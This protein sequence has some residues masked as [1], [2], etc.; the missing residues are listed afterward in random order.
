VNVVSCL[1][2]TL[3]FESSSNKEKC[4]VASFIAGVFH[5]LCYVK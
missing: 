3:T 4:F 5:E 2:L 1:T